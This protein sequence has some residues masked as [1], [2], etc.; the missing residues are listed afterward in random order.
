VN[1]QDLGSG[2]GQEL[3]QTPDSLT[4]KRRRC[5]LAHGASGRRS[6]E[7]QR[8]RVHFDIHRRGARQELLAP[9]HVADDA[10]LGAPPALRGA[11]REEERF[12]AGHPDVTEIVH[13]TACAAGSFNHVRC[14]LPAL[15][16]NASWL[17]R[18][19]T[20]PKTTIKVIITSL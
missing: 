9:L 3:P 11:E 6:R 15:E 1:V 10:G 16:R 17:V 4:A 2:V 5:D 13:H 20:W 8:E 14:C 18:E 7:A 19:R 12:H